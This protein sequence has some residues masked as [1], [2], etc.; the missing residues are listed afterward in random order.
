LQQTSRKISKGIAKGGLSVLGWLGNVFNTL[1]TSG[2]STDYGQTSP[3]VNMDRTRV[4]NAR[5]DTR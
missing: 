4:A 1:I 2:A 3:F 5:E